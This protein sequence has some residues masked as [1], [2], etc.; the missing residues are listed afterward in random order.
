[1]RQ[2]KLWTIKL[3]VLIFLSLFSVN[4]VYAHQPRLVE[5]G[6][7]T[8]IENP[9]V[10]QAFYGEMK[11]KP[12][13]YEIDAK[14]SFKL[15][16]GL[17]VP[18]VPEAKKDLSV[19]IKRDDEQIFYLNG[20][21]YEWKYF[22]EEF[23]NDNYWRGP[24]TAPIGTTKEASPAGLYEIMVFSPDNTGKYSLAVGEIESFPLKEIINTVF[25]LPKIK[26][27]IFDKSPFTAFFNR[28]GFYIFFPMLIFAAVIILIF[29]VI[30]KILRKNINLFINFLKRIQIF[31]LHNVIYNGIS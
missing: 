22:Y 2:N 19:I 26:S 25:T 10:P 15:Y 30:I 6:V 28:I 20:I 23:G 31:F 14:S 18:D 9:E 11:G 16:V 8:N 29:I 12:D 17:L 13:I 1:M 7:V 24:E 3:S 5:N 4:S 27:A 21:N